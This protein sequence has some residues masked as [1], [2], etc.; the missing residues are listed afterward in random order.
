MNLIYESQ[1]LDQGYRLIAGLDEVGRG[2][3]AGPVVAAAIILPFPFNPPWLELVK[4]SKELTPKRREILF[5][6]IEEEAL[7]I[8]IGLIPGEVIDQ[9]GI[10]PAT[11]LAMLQAIQNLPLSPQF[12]LIDALHIPSPLPQQPIIRGDKQCLSIA[13]A[14]IIAKVTR[15][16]LMKE[17]EKAY[18][19]Y[20]FARNKGYA[21]KEHLSAL[22]LLGPSPIHRKSFKPIRRLA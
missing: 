7:G 14:S 21:T 10:V 17:M 3:L 9:K 19:G 18:P 8:G 6:Y 5:Q 11:R 16:K 12:L 2:A 13:C 22:K 15:D 1:L 20:G 4:D